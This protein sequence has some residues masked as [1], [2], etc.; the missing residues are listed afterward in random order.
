M[1]REAIL[2]E[3]RAALEALGVHAIEACS[4]PLRGPAGNVE[5]FFRIARDGTPVDDERI[6]ALVVEAN[7]S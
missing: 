4:S 6:D 7:A 1:D 3:V 5:F 2:R